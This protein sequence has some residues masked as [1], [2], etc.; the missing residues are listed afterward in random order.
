MSVKHKPFHSDQNNDFEKHPKQDFQVERLAF[1][2]D[3]VFAIAITLLTIEFK[4]PHVT[5][6]TTFESAWEQLLDLRYNLFALVLSFALIATYWIRHHFLFKHIHNYNRQI[7]FANMC[8][9]LP[10][11]FFPFTT[12]FFAESIENKNVVVLALR[13]FIL[14]HILAGLTIYVLYWLALV[15]H[16]EMAFQ[17]TTPERNEFSFDILFTIIIF[18]AVLLTTFITDNFNAVSWTIFIGALSKK[19]LETFFKKRLT[20]E[21]AL[22]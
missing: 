2:S 1:F 10:V 11:I 9:L 18:V 17:M 4:V 13:C 21:R 12:A 3:A 19:M 6:D 14:N 7:I 20:K 15:K 16:K 8:V 5:K 22:P